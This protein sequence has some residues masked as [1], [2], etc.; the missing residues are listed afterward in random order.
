MKVVVI[1]AGMVGSAVVG[2]L[3]GQGGISEIALLDINKEKAEGEVLDYSH[4]TSYNYN[5]SAS[6][7]IGEYNSCKGADLIVMTAGPSIKEGETR[8]DLARK[9]AN[10][11]RSVMKEI[12][13]YTK[14]AI[15]I[16]VSN[17]VDVVTYIA[18]K[19]FGYDRKK[20]VG[21]GTLVDSARLM[22][23]IGNK[24]N[25]DP[26]NIFAYILGEH[27]ATSFAPW[28]IANICGYSLEE[29]AK[30][31]GF[32]IHLDKAGVEE[33]VRKIGF[34]IWSKKGYTNHGI[35][36][37]V[38]RMVKAI[39]LNERSILPVSTLLEGEYGLED[40]ALSVPCVV[41]REGVEDIIELPLLEEEMDKIKYSARSLKGIISDIKE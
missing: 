2:E 28:S 15:I 13:K 8:R 14:D 21:T 16:P 11:T 24:Y 39:L 10:I 37:G 3:L 1:G 40:V 27:G 9:N 5:P 22:R 41:G 29:F 23:F 25:L 36:A 26:K 32:N 34:E 6:L 31:R 33:R 35:A 30:L 17:P 20:I 4:T 12:V 19:E 18:A 38:G 7:K